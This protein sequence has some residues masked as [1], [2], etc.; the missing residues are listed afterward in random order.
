MENANFFTFFEPQRC[1]IYANN[2][3]KGKG[4][5]DIFDTHRSLIYSKNS[6]TKFLTHGLSLKKVVYRAVLSYLTLSKFKA[7][8]NLSVP[9]RMGG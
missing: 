8:N 4:F 9:Y 2:I 5:S 3:K 6:F 1:M 7:T